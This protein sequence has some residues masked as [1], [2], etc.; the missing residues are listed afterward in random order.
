MRSIVAECYEKAN[1]IESA[2]NLN[3][4]ESDDD[5]LKA[6]DVWNYKFELVYR[7]QKSTPKKRKLKSLGRTKRGKKTPLDKILS[8]RG[9]QKICCSL[10]L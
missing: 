7:T 9:D 8:R 6:N 4:R 2:S 5:N 10:K 1:V 3:P